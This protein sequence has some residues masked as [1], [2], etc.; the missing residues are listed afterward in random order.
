MPTFGELYYQENGGSYFPPNTSLWQDISSGIGENIG[1]ELGLD[2]IGL[3]EDG[4]VDL[5]LLN[6]FSGL[7]TTVGEENMLNR[8]Y[9]SAEARLN[10]EWNAEQAALNRIFNAEEAAKNRDFQER[11]SSTAYQRSVEDMRKAGI[12]PILMASSGFSA[13]SP[14]GSAASGSAASGSAAYYQYG[15]GDTL[16]QLIGALASSASSITRMFK[17]SKGK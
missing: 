6:Y 1:N 10:R 9:N 15:G 16:S 13:S 17:F 4:T 5:S 11:M 14:S 7:M 2:K 12:N 3:N 8:E